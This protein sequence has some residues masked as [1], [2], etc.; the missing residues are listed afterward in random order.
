MNI[1]EINKQGKGRSGLEEEEEEREE[2][3]RPTNSGEPPTNLPTNSNKF[4]IDLAYSERLIKR[5]YENTG[6]QV[7]TERNHSLNVILDS[8][9][10]L[11]LFA[12]PRNRREFSL[13]DLVLKNTHT[14]TLLEFRLPKSGLDKVSLVMCIRHKDPFMCLIG[15]VARNFWYRFDFFDGQ[16]N[17]INRPRF[18]EPEDFDIKLLFTSKTPLKNKVSGRYIQLLTKEAF[19]LVGIKSSNVTG[20][21]L[22]VMIA[23]RGGVSKEQVEQQQ[24]WDEENSNIIFE[25]LIRV[26][27]G[28]K[29]D[30]IYHIE[31]SSFKPSESLRRK[32]FPWL[33]ESRELW[34]QYNQGEP[35]EPELFEM[36]DCF[37]D[38]ILQDLIIFVEECPQSVFSRSKIAKDP[39]FL[40]FMESSSRSRGIESK[41]GKNVFWRLFELTEKVKGDLKEELR[42]EIGEE[43]RDRIEKQ[44]REVESHNSRINDLEGRAQ[45]DSETQES[46]LEIKQLLV[47]LQK[48]K[49]KKSRSRREEKR[50]RK[51]SRY[52]KASLETNKVHKVSEGT[53]PN[54]NYYPYPTPYGDA[55][56]LFNPVP[57]Q[58]FFPPFPGQPF[59]PTFIPPG[60][61][62]EN[63]NLYQPQ[64]AN[65]I[66]ES[67]ASTRPEKAQEQKS[68]GSR[69]VQGKSSRKSSSRGK[70]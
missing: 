16:L 68:S 11:V 22:G 31:R 24:R 57:H 32:V 54:P 64:E 13:G 30:E 46:I 23:E 40:E 20:E 35:S 38:F 3:N 51:K 1:E 21:D 70:V 67:S 66:V 47:K 10:G 26:V 63:T 36:L 8:L 39:E 60:A 28:F 15:A 6:S 53:A 52:L 44:L 42:R 37:R 5:L 41:L 27:A 29:K 25:D 2:G 45:T 65:S 19:E 12:R 18:L 56:Q 4:R 58:M 33:E 9:M 7:L 62:P 48:D 69:N 50:D 59:A 17:G 61:N 34:T 49:E 14:W 55:P 43:F